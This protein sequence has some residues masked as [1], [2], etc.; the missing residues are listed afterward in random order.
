MRSFSAARRPAAAISLSALPEV[1]AWVVPDYLI[2]RI[3]GR[4]PRPVYVDSAD[5]M[6]VKNLRYSR[7]FQMIKQSSSEL[8]ED[9]GTHRSH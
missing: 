6:A 8:A 9:E 2:G 4:S 5:G 3:P 1:H 7:E